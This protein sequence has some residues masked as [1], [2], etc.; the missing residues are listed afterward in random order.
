[1]SRRVEAREN[2][3][4]DATA[5]SPRA[6]LRVPTEDQ[7]W[8]VFVGF[9]KY[10]ALSIYFGEDPVFHFNSSGQLR[11]AF[12]DDRLMKAEQGRLIELRSERSDSSVVLQRHELDDNQQ[13]HFCD[14][15][16]QRLR[17]LTEA[18]SKGLL[19]VESQIPEDANV[20]ELLR[21]CLARVQDVS[22]ADSP[23]VL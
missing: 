5:L 6:Q 4:R 7:S 2:L 12:V 15:L 21:E 18:I 20:V 11:R 14:Q 8:E 10:Q 23:R 3:L 13:R 19:R 9:R 22:V 17:V 1:M 16:A